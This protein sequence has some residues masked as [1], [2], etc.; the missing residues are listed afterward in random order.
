MVTILS[1]Y[2]TTDV[3]IRDGLNAASTFIAAED[4]TE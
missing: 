2:R 3:K 1:G 4:D